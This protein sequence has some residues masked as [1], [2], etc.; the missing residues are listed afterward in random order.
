MADYKK[1][2]DTAAVP[3]YKGKVTSKMHADSFVIAKT[4]KN[5]DAAFVVLQYL[6]G[7]ASD[8]LLQTYGAMPARISKQDSYFE[9]F[10]ADKF[11][12]KTINWQVV[13][14]SAQ[15]ADNPNH[16]SWM[17]SYQEAVNKY[18]EFFTKLGNEAGLDVDKEVETL[19]GDLQKIFD[20]ASK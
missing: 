5:A 20:A 8:E 19:K 1:E 14:D 6:L 17:P 3:S 2:W 9:K 15:F 7:E 16:E 13:K 12:G 10:G 4:S 11:P 18:N